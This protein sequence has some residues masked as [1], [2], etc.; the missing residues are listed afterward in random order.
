MEKNKASLVSRI[1]YLVSRN[2]RYASR[3]TL[4]AFWFLCLSTFSLAQGPRTLSGLNVEGLQQG[5]GKEL[6]WKDN[7]FVQPVE[8][9]DVQ[10]LH[11]TAVVAGD[12]DSACLI[13]GEVLRVGD[14]IGFSEVVHIEKD[15]VVLRNENG[16]FGLSLKGQAPS[17]QQAAPLPPA[18]PETK[19]EE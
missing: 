18:V 13:N 15:H 6:R 11:L 16:I 14:K 4:Y 3:T 12:R 8:S 17:V 2:A 1:S 5:K 19:T 9:L 10:D 7:P